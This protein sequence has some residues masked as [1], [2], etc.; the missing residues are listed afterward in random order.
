MI[1]VCAAESESDVELIE[2]LPRSEE[3]ER[4]TIE[5]DYSLCVWKESGDGGKNGR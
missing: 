4:C 5:C 1:C 3:V 2:D